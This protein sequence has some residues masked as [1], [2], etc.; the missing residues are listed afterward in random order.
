MAAMWGGGV[1]WS[2]LRISRVEED[3]ER[4]NSVLSCRNACILKVS[5]LKS[6]EHLAAALSLLR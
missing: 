3:W 6:Y 4:C 2:M 5:P 1:V